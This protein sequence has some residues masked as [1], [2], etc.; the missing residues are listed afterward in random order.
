[1]ID[2]TKIK[3]DFPILSRQVNGKPLTYLDN[4]AT[5][6]KPKQ[7]I[8]AIVNY[9]SQHNANVHRGIHTLGDE[10]TRLYQQARQ[11]VATF[12]GATDPNELLFV[13]NTTEAINLVMQTWG[14]AAIG[15]GDV[16]LTTQMEH[17]SDMVPWQVLAKQ[18]GATVL[19]VGVKEDGTLAMADYEAKLLQKPKLVAVVHVSNFLGVI[20]PVAEMAEKAHKVGALMLVDAA[21]SVPHQKI[22][23]QKLGVDF[24]AFSGHKMMGPMGIGGLWVK[25]EIL[26]TLPPFLYGGGMIDE[27]T[28]E[29]TTYTDVPDR[30]DAGTP[31]VAGAVGL[32]AAVDYLSALGMEAVA[33]HEKSLMTYALAK[34]TEIKGLHL[35][36]PIDI[37]QKSG[38]V[39]FSLDG[40]HAHD[41]AQIL[42]REFGV[43]VRSGHHCVMPLHV[44]YGE[45]ATTRASFYVYNDQADVDVL[46]EGIYAVQKKFG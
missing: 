27:V 36:G 5:S 40:I 43:A 31:N 8:E 46:V 1:M 15:K 12:I 16:I 14:Q 41:V 39:A 22:D 28:F 20:N 33:Q 6:Q 25:K 3:Q 42:D 45:P 35:F 23:V 17:H 26:A 32:A 7:V 13:R 44:A 10:A 30:F 18:K 11:T 4:A 19:Y 24:L 37:T 34:L 21:Q 2:V 9:Y 38:V 29:G